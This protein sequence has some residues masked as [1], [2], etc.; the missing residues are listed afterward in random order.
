MAKC[1]N[2]GNEVAKP[3]KTIDNRMFHLEYYVCDN[4]GKTFTVS[5]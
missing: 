4:C 1:P 3:Q 5:S 2:C